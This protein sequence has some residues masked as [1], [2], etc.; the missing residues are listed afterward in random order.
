MHSSCLRLWVCSLH[1]AM[2]RL[3]TMHV[4]FEQHSATV[5]PPALHKPIAN[6]CLEIVHPP[7][8]GALR[9]HGR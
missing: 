5:W 7:A 6:V 1:G 9:G 4:I 2:R 3:R 8:Q